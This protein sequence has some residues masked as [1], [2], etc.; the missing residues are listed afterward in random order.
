MTHEKRRN[1]METTQM[2]GSDIKQ[3]IEQFKSTYHLKETDFIYEVIQEP[4]KGIL[5]FIGKKNGIVLFTTDNVSEEIT[6]YFNEL[7]KYMDIKINK[8]NIKKNKKYINVDIREVSDPGFLIGKDGR[9]LENLQ[10]LINQTFSKK[11]IHDR[12]IILDIEGYK[13][14]QE[15]YLYKKISQLAEQAQKTQRSITLDPMPAAQRRIV[16]EVIKNYE[17]LK[18]ITIGEG[19]QKRVVLNPINRKNKP[20]Q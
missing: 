14:R 10:Y 9:L 8:I 13:E 3:I 4:K 1:T 16:H 7:A 6:K 2:Q 5:G 19:N 20:K 15:H 17:N 12:N 11:D 18:T